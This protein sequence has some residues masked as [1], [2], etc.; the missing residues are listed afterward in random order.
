MDRRKTCPKCNN[1][2]LMTFA[3]DD[4]SQDDIKSNAVM[5]MVCRHVWMEVWDHGDLV[6]VGDVDLRKP[7]ATQSEETINPNQT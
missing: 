5:C 6:A 3:P 2:H 4:T 1:D 7:D